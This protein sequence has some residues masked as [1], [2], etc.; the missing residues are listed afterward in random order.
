MR[1]GKALNFCKFASEPPI[2]SVH[3]DT[4]AQPKVS[5][6]GCERREELDMRKLTLAACAAFVG[7]LFAG[8]AFG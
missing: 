8:S 6:T 2:A 4:G 1:S 3:T 5:M 7:A